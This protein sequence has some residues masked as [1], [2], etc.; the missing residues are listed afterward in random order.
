MKA[1]CTVH[2][3]LLLRKQLICRALMRIA[4]KAALVVDDVVVLVAS[5]RRLHVEQDAPL[6]LRINDFANGAVRTVRGGMGRQTAAL[7]Y[8]LRCRARPIANLGPWE[9]DQDSKIDARIAL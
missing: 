8:L 3:E 2:L 7:R 9:G 6:I 5:D 4:R 1:Q